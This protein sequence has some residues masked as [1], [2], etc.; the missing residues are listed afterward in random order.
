MMWTESS[1]RAA[2]ERHE[3]ELF[4]QP[5]VL[6]DGRTIAG[7][8]ALVRHIAADG[9]VTGPTQFIAA[10]ERLG[11]IDELTRYSFPRVCEAAVRW[12]GLSIAV[13]LSPTEFRQHG[14][15]ER[16][17]GTAQAAGADP[18][19]IEIEVT[20]GLFFDDPD[21]AEVM[22]ADL[23]KA[24]FSIALD[25]FGTGYS[26]LAYLLR[27]PVDKIKIDRS[28]VKDIPGSLKAASIVHALI[29]LARAIG[30]KVVAE[31]VETEEQR[32]FLKSAGCHLQQGYLFST[33]VPV[34]VF[35]T[36][37]ASSRA[38]APLP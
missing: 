2:L 10:F 14:L 8:E 20:E 3:F 33:P 31:G 32:V 6:G 9:T 13:N 24:G 28:F 5:Q 4:Y 15:V 19:R 27:F 16:L 30:L 36:M 11:F 34:R 38:A 17:V 23:R 22:L 12:P 37:L 25:D 35:E 7:A 21:R 18:R 1:F 29:A 26:S